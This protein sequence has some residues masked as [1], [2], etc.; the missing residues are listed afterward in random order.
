[1]SPYDLK[2]S[3]NP[4]ACHFNSALAPTLWYANTS[5]LSPYGQ[6]RVWKL[7]N[8]TL[9]FKVLTTSTEML[10]YAWGNYAQT[11][12]CL[13]DSPGAYQSEHVWKG[14]ER[15]QRYYR[16]VWYKNPRNASTSARPH[17]DSQI[18]VEFV[19]SPTGTRSLWEQPHCVFF[20]YYYYY[21]S[22]MYYMQSDLG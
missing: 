17:F 8:R 20:Y 5:H 6:C 19:S 15:K 2:F 10:F 18:C 9:Q 16:V 22:I 7:S 11:I 12:C 1:M 14:R 13:C 3:Y 4:V 21:S